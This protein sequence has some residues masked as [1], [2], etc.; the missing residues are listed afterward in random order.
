MTWQLLGL[1]TVLQ[2]PATEIYYLCSWG[3]R[4]SNLF[5][6]CVRLKGGVLL[7][8]ARVCARRQRNNSKV[9][10]LGRHV[11]NSA[12][13]GKPRRTLGYKLGRFIVDT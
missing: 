10:T 8:A 2:S 12:T 1:W 9:P 5:Y 4:D 3:R 13:S 6:F 11:H 7:P